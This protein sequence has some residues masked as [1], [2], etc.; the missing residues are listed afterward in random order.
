MHTY[1]EHRGLRS[2]ESQTRVVNRTHSTF[3][4]RAF[5]AA[6]LR[7]WNSLPPHLRDADLPYSQ[8]RWSLKTFLFGQWDHS[9]VWTIL[10]APSRNHHTYLLT[11]LLN[12]GDMQQHLVDHKIQNVQST[13]F[14]CRLC[15]VSRHCCMRCRMSGCADGTME[16]A[17]AAVSE[18]VDWGRCKRR[19]SNR[20]SNSVWTIVDSS[21]AFCLNLCTLMNNHHQQA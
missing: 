10:T 15:T 20:S 6:G 2:T 9:A 1:A 3:V 19:A 16:S 13:H 7:L 18:E 21:W 5:A 14:T 4:D 17:A 11:Y 12:F 8:F